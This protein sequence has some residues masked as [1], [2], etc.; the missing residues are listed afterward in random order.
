MFKKL[1]KKQFAALIMACVML[2]TVFS[3]ALISVSAENVTDI[4]PIGYDYWPSYGKGF[5]NQTVVD[6][7]LPTSI[8]EMEIILNGQTEKLSVKDPIIVGDNMY[9]VSGKKLLCYD[10]NGKKISEAELYERVGFFSRIAAGGGKIYVALYNRLQA[11]DAETLEPLWLTPKVSGQ[12]ISTITYNDGYVYTGFTSGGSGGTAATDGGYFCVSS[13]DEDTQNKFEEKEF[14]WMSET[15]G[16][17]WAGGVVVGDKIYFVG[18]SGVLYAHHLT[19]DIVYDTYDLGG[20]VRINLIYDNASNR[21]MAAT[22]DTAILYSIEL[23]ESGTFNKATI[24]KS[25]KGVI[26][27]VTGGISSYN[28]RVYVPS[29][30]MHA[31]GDFMVLDAETLEPEYGIKGLKSQSTP[32]ICTA[33]ATKENNQKVYVYAVDFNSGV[34]IVFED[35][36]GQKEYKEA[37]RIEN[38]T[39]INNEEHK[40]TGYNSSSIKADQNGNLYFIGGS[41]SYFGSYG[42]DDYES[43]ATSYALSIFRNKNAEFTAKDVENKIN[44]LP[45]TL[46]YEDKQVV[47]EL[48]SRFDGLSEE[49]QKN[50]SNKDTLLKA[51]E[52]IEQL[53]MD[54]I[55]AAQDEINK[56]SDPITL[57]D[58]ATIENAN[59]L[60]GKLSE[61]DK[62]LVEN[63]NDLKNAIKV[64]FELK[65]SVAGLIEK[66]EKLPAREDIT[67]DDTAAVN[68]LWESY[69]ALSDNDKEKITNRQ[70]LFD[71]KDKLKELS[72]KLLVDEFIKKIE[73]IPSSDKVTLENEK[74]VNEL[75]ADFDALHN[76]A[77][78][79]ITNRDKLIKTHEKVSEYR[80]AVD[81]IDNLIWDKLDP[82]N[83]TLKDKE[84]IQVI[85]Q[86]YAALRAEEQAFVKNY[87]DVKDAKA[88]IV[89][90]EQGIIPQQVFENIADADKNYTVEGEGYTITFNG[91][92]ILNPAD[93]KYGITVDSALNNSNGIKFTFAQSGKFPGKATVSIDVDLKDGNYALYKYDEN[94][95][96]Q[97]IQM[98]KV[99]NGKAVFTLSE[100]GSYGIDTATSPQTGVIAD[101]MIDL[102]IVLFGIGFIA[103]ALF[104]LRKKQSI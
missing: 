61:Q 40:L 38:K 102:S 77:K 66:I 65:A 79:L 34:L 45:E 81:E 51:V 26:G 103:A 91:N 62:A 54:A 48:K 83:I 3:T 69:N 35:S 31:W 32:V 17:Y 70:K 18:D 19:E 98:V 22:K 20:Q 28:G 55:K 29:G 41:N 36:K 53:T 64:V 21:L 9:V 84:L 13:D 11:F 37:F 87:R 86:K 42:K 71:A 89:S 82:L 95:K 97:K 104:V 5:D 30:G 46:S 7:K 100:G 99:E 25:E 47:T 8:D 52:T 10:L 68:E 72:D 78:E 6:S 33:Y 67:A 59:R 85:D 63:Q 93:F 24:K 75:F 12:M 15:G 96:A 74:A 50:V 27:G 56:I 101:N 60:Y 39:K 44:L 94:N 1:S 92:D 16:Y 49:E 73:E 90:L 80:K 57:A 58:E 76:A 14:T 23:T 2:I 88:I 43:G 4:N